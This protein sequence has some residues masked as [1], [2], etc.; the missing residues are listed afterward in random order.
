MPPTALCSLYRAY[1]RAVRRLPHHYLRYFFQIRARD[2]VDAVAA[3]ADPARQLRKINDVARRVRRLQRATARDAKAFQRILALAY[4]RTGKLRWELLHPMLTDPTAPPPA[5][6]I[7][8]LP[9]T[10]PPVYP[11][12]LKHLLTVPTL[13]H[14]KALTASELA[15]PR[16]LPD[17]ADPTSPDALLFGPFS[18]RLEANLRKRAYD[19]AL[20]R[21]QPPLE[22][23]VRSDDGLNGTDLVVL[24][25]VRTNVYPRPLA[26]QG[27]GLMRDI[28]DLIGNT[29]SIPPPTPRR[30]RQAAPLNEPASNQLN[31]TGQTKMHPFRWVRRRYRNLLA[32]IPQLTYN[33]THLP[34]GIRGGFVVETP[35]HS[36]HPN[37][38]SSHYNP[39]ADAVS[40]AWVASNPASSSTPTPSPSDLKSES[41][42]VN[43]RKCNENTGS[44]SLNKQ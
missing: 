28:N 4:G 29:T 17:R 20:K 27:L 18:K 8:A 24:D 40:L 38:R 7:P 9:R 32:S 36:I 11:P 43:S 21:V 14:K 16:I 10:A 13:K 44:N 35:P 26:M 1:L 3:L 41:K 34:S 37:H 23:T 6:I 15:K 30:A 42:N 2:D 33:V 31:D 5:P 12:E 25:A 22:V 39:P 19:L